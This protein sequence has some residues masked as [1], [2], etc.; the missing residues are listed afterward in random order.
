MG[1]AKQII[2]YTIARSG[3]CLMGRSGNNRRAIL[4]NFAKTCAHVY[5]FEQRSAV[6]VRHSHVVIHGTNHHVILPVHSACAAA[7]SV[8]L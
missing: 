3:R 5:L 8:D 4:T 6:G 7:P 1:N 2:H